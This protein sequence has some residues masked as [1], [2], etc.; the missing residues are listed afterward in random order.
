MSGV[1]NY[2]FK[3]AAAE[4]EP[5][6]SLNNHGNGTT[7][8]D[9]SVSNRNSYSQ[10]Q[11]SVMSDSSNGNN[12]VSD[13]V[14]NSNSNPSEET[15]LLLNDTGSSSKNTALTESVTINT[16]ARQPQSAHK[17]YFPPSNPSIQRYYRFTVTPLQPM[18]ALYKRPYTTSSSN[19]SLQ[20][21]TAPVTGIL[22][23]SAVVP[24]HGTDASGT[25]ILGTSF[26]C[27]L[28]CYSSEKEKK[29]IDI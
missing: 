11:D 10:P 15:A 8:H 3:G 16:K 20:D 7:S 24:S 21:S 1:Y 26:E 6:G 29:R 23:R 9:N 17:F 12:G 13:E 2:L 25:W 4:S 18:A 5:Q 22:R 27:A 14:A 19:S 28:Y